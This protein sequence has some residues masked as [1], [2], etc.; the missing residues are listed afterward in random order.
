M[1]EKYRPGIS[2]ISRPD[3]V[4]FASIGEELLRGGQFVS[5]E[6]GLHEGDGFKILAKPTD[7]AAALVEMSAAT[8]RQLRRE[9]PLF[10]LEPSVRVSPAVRPAT[11][12]RRPP[13]RDRSVER[14][15]ITISV[16]D[17]QGSPVVGARVLVYFDE[18]SRV[19]VSNKTR[20]SGS[21]S[22]LIPKAMRTIPRLQVEPIRGLIGYS[23]VQVAA[24]GPLNVH[25][26]PVVPGAYT[27]GLRRHIGT[28]SVDGGTGVRIAVIDSGVDNTHPNLRHVTCR[29][30]V[31]DGQTTFA[32]Y[33]GTHVAGIIGARGPRNICGIAPAAELSSF[34]I[35]PVDQWDSEVFYLAMGISEAARSDVH[36]INISMTTKRMASLLA[37]AIALA[38]EKGAVCIAA[39]GNEGR[40]GVS[41]PAFSKRVLAVSAYADSDGLPADCAERSEISDVVSRTYPNLSRARFSNWGAEIDFMAPGV[42][43][44]SCSPGGTYAVDSG[45]S[46]ATPVLTGLAAVMLSASRPDILALGPTPARSSAIVAAITESAM[47]LGFGFEVQG[48]G[49]IGINGP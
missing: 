36:L 14:K 21:V 20:A 31:E 15:K 47:S 26:R 34:R 10:L 38:H 37:D 29:H 24:A 22:F 4:S 28:P 3:T 39:S 8:A 45:T 32:H 6:A 30:V 12:L 25:L 27:D 13:A 9:S 42:G 5:E 41:L 35:V 16:K 40:K 33:H 48:N 18:T 11:R 44:I 7:E 43:I 1:D 49:I 2:D 23:E 17:A 46:M 19:G